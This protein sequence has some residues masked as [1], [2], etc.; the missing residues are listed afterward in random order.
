MQTQTKNTKNL[1]S[2]IQ[3]FKKSDATTKLL[4]QHEIPSLTF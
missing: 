1:D 2:I 4:K 3:N